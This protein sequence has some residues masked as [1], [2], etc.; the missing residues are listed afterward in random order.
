VHNRTVV[1]AMPSSVLQAATCADLT[2]L[3]KPGVK[4]VCPADMRYNPEADTAKN[5]ATRTCCQVRT[6]AAATQ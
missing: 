4:F 1:H 3:S 2:P 5:P 6:A